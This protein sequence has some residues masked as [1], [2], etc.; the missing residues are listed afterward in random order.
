MSNIKSRW[1]QPQLIVLTRGN[2]EETLLTGCKTAKG[3]AGPNG[4]ADNGCAEMADSCKNCQARDG[5]S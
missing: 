4:Y 5:N 3:H 1:M 2:P